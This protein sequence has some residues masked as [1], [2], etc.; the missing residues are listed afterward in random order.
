MSYSHVRLRKTLALVRVL[1]GVLFIVFGENKISSLEFA[2]I[3]FPQFIWDAT[4]GTAATFYAGFLGN[5][6]WQH[7]GRY[8]ILVGF[9]ELF[10]GVGLTL[11]LAVRPIA[12]VGMTY[13]VNLAL[14][15]WMAPGPG[16]TLSR[17]LHAQLPHV[18]TFLLFFVFAIGHAG[19]NWGLGS[20][21]HHRRHLQWEQ[22]QER[23]PDDR[24]TGA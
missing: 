10:I 3:G 2:R 5:F 8:A 4:H 15:T 6:S 16:E 17:Y 21:Y 9:L 14:A 20:L 22:Q 12:I 18:L 11:G 7:I 13:M 23:V 24:R 19:E 1:T